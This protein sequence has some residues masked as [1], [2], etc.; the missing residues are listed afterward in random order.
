MPNE[1]QIDEGSRMVIPRSVKRQV[2]LSKM[3]FDSIKAVG[4]EAMPEGTEKK[5]LDTS[6]I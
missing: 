1:D 2:D 6:S 3:N 4:K 5:D